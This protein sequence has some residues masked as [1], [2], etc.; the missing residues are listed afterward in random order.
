MV[1]TMDG[2]GIC[3]HQCMLH[4]CST[5]FDNQLPRRCRCT[6]SMEEEWSISTRIMKIS[7]TRRFMWSRTDAHIDAVPKSGRGDFSARWLLGRGVVHLS[8]KQN[9]Q[10]HCP[11]FPWRDTQKTN[12][13]SGD[14]GH[15]DNTLRSEASESS[16][17]AK[18]A[19][20]TSV[21]RVQRMSR[22]DELETEG[23]G[24]R[25]C[26]ANTKNS[27]KKSYGSAERS[28]TW[29]RNSEKHKGSR[30]SRTEYDCSDKSPVGNGNVMQS[31]ETAVQDEEAKQNRIVLTLKLRRKLRELQED[32]KQGC[33]KAHG[34]Q[35]PSRHVGSEKNGQSRDPV[36]AHSRRFKRSSKHFSRSSQSDRECRRN[37]NRR[38]EGGSSISASHNI[39]KGR[40]G[41]ALNQAP[42]HDASTCMDKVS[43]RRTAAEISEERR[44]S[45]RPRRRSQS[46]SSDSA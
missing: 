14:M 6:R 22:E 9:M 10:E 23:C 18:R 12:G 43:V 46:S 8:N 38:S 28:K 2:V 17:S 25:H 26:C 7:S 39:F 19:K 13:R 32:I 42:Q 44:S 40:P 4:I 30:K 16:L 3:E 33:R 24:S 31:G 27:K 15:Q 37:W 5:L 21:S 35:S 20:H 41:I 45:S 29:R 36:R 11:V 1:A 34:V